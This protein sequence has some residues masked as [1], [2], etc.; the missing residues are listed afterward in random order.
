[1]TSETWFQQECR[2]GVSLGKGYFSTVHVVHHNRLHTQAAL[3]TSC[4]ENFRKFVSKHHSQLAIHDEARLLQSMS[5]PGIISILRWVDTPLAVLLILELHQQG[6]LLQS[7][8]GKGPWE[9]KLAMPLLGQLCEALYY[10][11][12]KDITHRDI[13]PDNIL[14][15]S[16]NRSFTDARIT[17]FGLARQDRTGT[18]CHTLCGTPA[19]L[20]P[21]RFTQDARRLGYG[22]PA[23][24]WSLGITLYILLSA[25]PPF[26]DELLREQVCGGSF[27]FDGDC[28]TSISE[29]SKRL[30][31]SLITVKADERITCKQLASHTSV[32]RAVWHNNNIHAPATFG[33]EFPSDYTGDGPQTKTSTQQVACHSRA[34]QQEKSDSVR[35]ES[36]PGFYAKQA[37]PEWLRD[38][39]KAQWGAAANRR[40][41]QLQMD[42]GMV[43]PRCHAK[44]KTRMQQPARH[45]T[46]ASANSS[47]NHPHPPIRFRPVARQF[48]KVRRIRKVKS[49]SHQEHTASSALICHPVY[50]IHD[51]VG[52]CVLRA[53]NFGSLPLTDLSLITEFLDTTSRHK[54]CRVGMYTIAVLHD[55][56]CTLGRE[57]GKWLIR[58]QAIARFVVLPWLNPLDPPQTDFAK[59]FPLVREVSD[60]E[61]IGGCGLSPYTDLSPR[62]AKFRRFLHSHASCM[63]PST[64]DDMEDGGGAK[65]RNT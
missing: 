27:E 50:T 44:P 47:A 10:L 60:R 53:N 57:Y 58:A 19:Y 7:I 9:E 41:Q 49:P 17:D 21:E 23:D 55:R 13:K 45:N 16:S 29:P 4:K 8:M 34:T 64:T 54:L 62:E 25:E 15:S 42:A 43:P 18:D 22:K 1:M 20:A 40:L 14:L 33:V 59:D 39:P 12:Q 28:W 24:L 37:A 61:G 31:R 51:L 48:K 5:H 6:D 52:A 26:D 3:K 56:T 11:H 65:K 30:T 38:L 35:T 46:S 2:I 63:S 32:P 36:Q